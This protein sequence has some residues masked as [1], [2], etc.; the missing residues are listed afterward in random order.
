MA[1]HPENGM[2]GGSS[3]VV[4][5]EPSQLGAVV[6]RR[7]TGRPWKWAEYVTVPVGCC[8]FVPYPTALAPR[9]RRDFHQRVR[10]AVRNAAL[11]LGVAIRSHQG[12]VG[13]E[14]WRVA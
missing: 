6:S 12:E 5:R 9:E 11:R 4:S 3:E 10:A 7:R 2:A 1:Q 13:I 8:S 14:F